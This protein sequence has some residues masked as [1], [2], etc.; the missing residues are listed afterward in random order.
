MSGWMSWLAGLFLSRTILNKY[1]LCCTSNDAKGEGEIT[2]YVYLLL[3][4]RGFMILCLT[5]V[6]LVRG[7]CHDDLKE[8]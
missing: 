2:T 6:K 8:N 7:I 5:I 1:R 4:T 3:Q